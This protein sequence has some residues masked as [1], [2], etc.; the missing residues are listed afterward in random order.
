MYRRAV[1][2]RAMNF[3]KNALLSSI[4]YAWEN[5]ATGGKLQRRYNASIKIQKNWRGKL[6][7]QFVKNKRFKI[8]YAEDQVMHMNKKFCVSNN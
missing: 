5:E 7:R 4:F 1:A 8:K 6:G 2:L 3:M